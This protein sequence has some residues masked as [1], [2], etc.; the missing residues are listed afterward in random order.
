M[1]TTSLMKTAGFGLLVLSLMGAGGANITYASQDNEAAAKTNYTQEVAEGSQTPKATPESSVEKTKMK[2]VDVKVNEYVDPTD[3]KAKEKASETKKASEPKKAEAAPKNNQERAAATE[4]PET[5]EF[6]S[7]DEKDLPE[8]LQPKREASVPRA[9]LAA[10]ISEVSEVPYYYSNEAVGEINTDSRLA[11]QKAYEAAYLANKVNVQMSNNVDIA[12]CEPGQSNVAGARA[13]VNSVNLFRSLNGLNLLELET[14]SNLSDYMQQTA[15]IMAANKKL[16]HLPGSDP[17]FTKCMK[18]GK[19][20]IEGAGISNLSEARGLSPADQAQ[21][22]MKDWS[23]R[24][25]HINDNLGHRLNLL[26]PAFARTAV[27]YAGGYEAVALPITTGMLPGV[28]TDILSNPHAV[29]PGVIAW[30]SQGYFPV[31]LLTGLDTKDQ[32]GYYTDYERWSVSLYGADLRNASVTVTG[33]GNRN[34]PI[35]S[36]VLK[37]PLTTLDGYNSLLIM[38]PKKELQRFSKSIVSGNS[39]AT[40]TVTINGIRGVGSSSYS[41]KVKLFDGD[42]PVTA[43]APKVYLQHDLVALKAGRGFS[44]LV[45]TPLMATGNPLPSIVWQRSDNNGYSWREVTTPVTGTRSVLALNY[46]DPEEITPR[47][48][49]RAKVSNSY[50]TVYTKIMTPSIMEITTKN[51]NTTVDRNSQFVVSMNTTFD[52]NGNWVNVARKAWMGAIRLSSGQVSVQDLSTESFYFR[53]GGTREVTVTRERTK[54][55]GVFSLT[56]YASVEIAAESGFTGYYLEGK[57]I[58]FTVR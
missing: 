18:A 8:E 20:G 34:I 11:V 4:V 17:D 21:W 39:E 6:G 29:T 56:P 43:S 44:M 23:N 25:T 48:M 2:T 49:F 36:S 45:D 1:N 40:Y 24:Q 15:M 46:R 55:P 54:V 38:F 30:P 16:S 12:N 33:P 10:P 53:N 14:S 58:T 52:G 42:M 26:N 31:Q 7:I 51:V 22:F 19:Y 5:N 41:Y 50:G 27:G 37:R 9:P 35:D 3:G 32:N 28:N 13:F 47:T 57:T